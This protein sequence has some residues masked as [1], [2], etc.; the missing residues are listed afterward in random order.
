[1]KVTIGALGNSLLG[2]D[3]VISVYLHSL[4]TLQYTGSGWMQLGSDID[5]SEAG[6]QAVYS[7][8]LSSDGNTVVVVG[9]CYAL[10]LDALVEGAASVHQL[11]MKQMKDAS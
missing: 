11:E 6:E 8:A 7:I 2:S 5:W 1:M 3:T 10:V 4:S 9:Q